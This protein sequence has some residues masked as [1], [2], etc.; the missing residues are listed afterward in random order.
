MAPGSVTHSSLTRGG[1]WAS[2]SYLLL[3]LES[4]Q[5]GQRAAAGG[6]LKP[7]MDSGLPQTLLATSARFRLFLG[8]SLLFCE[9]AI[10]VP[11][12]SL[13]SQETCFS[14]R[15][16]RRLTLGK[17]IPLLCLSLPICMLR[18]LD[19]RVFEWFSNSDILPRLI[20]SVDPVGP[21]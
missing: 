18:R 11:D 1:D 7:E 9:M 13:Q 6:A 8:L 10:A 20:D 4:F 12:L 21:W 5:P 15:I 14:S 3:Q 2:G 16:W 17:P 19:M